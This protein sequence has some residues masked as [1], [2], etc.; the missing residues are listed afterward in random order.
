M[1]YSMYVAG[2]THHDA[3]R[4]FAGLTLYSP[5]SGEGMYLVAMDG[6]VVHRWDPPGNTRF[7]YGQLLPNGNLLANITNGSELGEPAGPRTA[8]VSE[9]DWQGN[10]VWSHSDPVL[11]H[12]HCR[13][14]N[15]NTLVLATDVLDPEACARQWGA[16]AAIPGVS[17]WSESVWE[18][19]AAGDKVWQWHARD[20]LDPESYPLPRQGAGQEGPG[21]T[22]VE[23]LHLA[24]VP[25]SGLT[26]TPQTRRRCETAPEEKPGSG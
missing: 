1:G 10:I 13:L 26:A 16:D 15:G 23:W 12:A 20:H 22:Q 3:T 17:I 25:C 6:S 5:M 11:H 4:S 7:F 19:N 24:A 14:A 8:Q 21:R 18:L 9:I 2:L